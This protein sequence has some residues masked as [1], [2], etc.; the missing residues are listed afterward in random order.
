MIAFGS[1]LALTGFRTYDHPQK[2]NLVAELY[3]RVFY[4][5]CDAQTA[6][7]ALGVLRL[8]DAF[9]SHDRMLYV[10]FIT[11]H[12]DTKNWRKSPYV[13]FVWPA[14]L[15][16]ERLTQGVLFSE[17]QNVLELT[18]NKVFGTLNCVLCREVYYIVSLSHRVPY[19]RFH[20]IAACS[21]EEQSSWASV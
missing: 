15:F 1:G 8:I 3:L 4:G 14:R 11:F 7:R 12:I 9:Q 17:V 6:T 2:S 5:M 16:V 18:G 21:L 13:F 20:C 19:W 10:Y